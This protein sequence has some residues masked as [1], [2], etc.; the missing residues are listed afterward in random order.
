MEGGLNLHEESIYLQ[1]AIDILLRLKDDFEMYIIPA[2]K[3]KRKYKNED[4]SY[5]N[6][7]QATYE[8]FPVNNTEIRKVLGDGLLKCLLYDRQSLLRFLLGDYESLQIQS[9]ER[10]KKGKVI[11]CKIEIK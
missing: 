8:W 9:V 3:L 1:G 6:T 10:D 4:I 11:N 5:T 2:K 7:V